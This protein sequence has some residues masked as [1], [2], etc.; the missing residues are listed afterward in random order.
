VSTRWL[1]FFFWAYLLVL[2]WAEGTATNPA[3][4]DLWHRLALGETLW[5]THVFPPGGA[6]SYL[7]DYRNIADHEW[8]SALI[9][10]GLYE[11]GGGAAMVIMKLVTLTLTLMLLVWAGLQGRRPTALFAAFY[12]VVLL[13]LLPSFQ[14]TVRCMTFTHVFFALWLYWYQC[15]RHGRVIPALAYIFTAILWANLHGGFAIGLAWLL[16]VTLVEFWQ[17]GVWRKWGVLWLSCTLATL[18][19][20]FGWQL[21]ISTGR[22]L[23]TTRQGFDEWA[24]V[25]WW[26]NLLA[27]PG[28]KLLLLGVV[29][30]MVLLIYGR[31]W[32]R[33]DRGSI[34]LIGAA[35]ALSLTSARH[36][37]LFAAVTAALLPDLLPNEP[38]IQSFPNAVHRLSYLGVRFSLLLIPLYA[39]LSILPGDG[40][41]L[42]YPAVS[43]P[44]G[45]VDYL[46]AKGVRGRLL[47]PFNYGSYALWHLRGRIRVSMDGRYDLVY[48]PETYRKVDDF[49]FARGDWTELLHAPAPAAILLPLADPVYAKLKERSDWAESYHDETDA[50]FL[51]R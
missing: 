51:P 25:S 27:Y 33:V 17:G 19:N 11:A 46:E 12:A 50:V 36:T 35:L 22:A 13:A 23:M 4:P 18:V 37:S 21:W 31:G 29:T 1:K 43:C 20:P 9:F 28:Y 2:V 47:V 34:L 42:R 44:I 26:P 10:Y 30:G 45:A 6:F 15:E 14:S 38:P 40:L 49:F 32:R 16:G 5:Q 24:P 7:A 39:A 3:D 41:E 48:R 8:G